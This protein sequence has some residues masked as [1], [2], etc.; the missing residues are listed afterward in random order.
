MKTAGLLAEFV[1]TEDAK[2][3]IAFFEKH[4]IAQV[5]P[6]KDTHE[7]H[8]YMLDYDWPENTKYPVA[9]APTRYVVNFAERRE[10]H[11]AIVTVQFVVYPNGTITRFTTWTRMSSQSVVPVPE[12][13]QLERLIIETLISHLANGL[14]YTIARNA[15]ESVRTSTNGLS[16][17][18]CAPKAEKAELAV[19]VVKVIKQET[20]N[21]QP[22]WQYLR[23]PVKRRGL[24]WFVECPEHG[25][26]GIIFQI[27]D[28]TPPTDNR[29]FYEVF[30]N[31]MIS[32]ANT[33]VKIVD[34]GFNIDY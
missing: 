2:G 6:D 1:K 4:C 29:Q 10:D 9:L 24:M 27:V 12:V 26:F 34:V 18:W 8:H 16:E 15:V 7:L 3:V 25:I 33:C 20:E 23:L 11:G 19:A 14:G 13:I 30:V 17:Y 32:A 22:V 31:N 21:P 28:N 5:P